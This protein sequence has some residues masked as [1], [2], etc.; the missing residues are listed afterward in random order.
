ML[1]YVASVSDAVS[2]ARTNKTDSYRRQTDHIAR[3]PV[4]YFDVTIRDKADRHAERQI[5]SVDLVF[6][7]GFGSGVS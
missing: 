4:V 1:R 3:S 7:A 6:F 2:F 5:L